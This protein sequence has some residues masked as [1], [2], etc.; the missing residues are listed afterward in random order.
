MP[1]RIRE[2]RQLQKI[3]QKQLADMTGIDVHS[4]HRYESGETRPDVEIAMR[5]S[6]ALGK[7]TDE[8]FWV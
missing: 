1:N 8:V 2:L 6:H 5:I 7:K 4:V 3:S